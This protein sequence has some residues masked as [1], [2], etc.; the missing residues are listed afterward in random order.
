M[1]VINGMILSGD[2]SVGAGEPRV[3]L[4]GDHDG[5]HPHEF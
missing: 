3:S 5:G 1:T 4:L 2:L